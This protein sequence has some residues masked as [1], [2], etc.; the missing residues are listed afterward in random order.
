[1]GSTHRYV[2]AK[3]PELSRNL[4]SHKETEVE[5][6]DHLYLVLPSGLFLLPLIRQTQQISMTQVKLTL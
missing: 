4:S 2:A 3:S 1:M 5:L 6:E